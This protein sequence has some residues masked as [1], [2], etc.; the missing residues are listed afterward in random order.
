MASFMP[1]SP[2]S[3]GTSSWCPLYRKP[4]VPNDGL[5]DMEKN[6]FLLLGNRSTIPLSS[7]SQPNPYSISVYF[8]LTFIIV[9]PYI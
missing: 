8:Y 3:H 9:A 1:L 2:Y 5:D 4:V 6:K 7:T